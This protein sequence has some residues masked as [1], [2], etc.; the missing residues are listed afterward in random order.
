MT[1]G[2]LSNDIEK[3]LQDVMETSLEVFDPTEEDEQLSEKQCYVNDEHDYI[4]DRD[5]NNPDH[6]SKQR[7]IREQRASVI[8]KEFPRPMDKNAE[9]DTLA[10]GSVAAM[11]PLLTEP[12]Q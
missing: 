7:R 12:L 2:D 1:Y 8:V 11:Q 5:R 10:P 3:I 4:N 9:L 6:V